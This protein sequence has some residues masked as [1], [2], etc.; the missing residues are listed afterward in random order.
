MSYHQNMMVKYIIDFWSC[1]LTLVHFLGEAPRSLD[2]DSRFNYSLRLYDC[3]S[4]EFYRIE[5]ALD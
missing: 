2:F 4:T 1:L 3:L 5:F